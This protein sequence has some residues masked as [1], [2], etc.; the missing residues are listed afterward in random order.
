MIT[1]D[2][3]TAL[4]KIRPHTT[5]KQDHQRKPAQLLVALEST[6]RETSNPIKSS[7]QS[8]TAYFAA[9]IT[10]LEGCLS[11]G[12]TTLNE[13]DTLPAIL[14]LLALVFPF[15]PEP[16]LRSHMSK[17]FQIIPPLLPL[18]IPSHAPSLRSLITI[19]GTAIAAMDQG[20][21]LATVSSSVGSSSSAISV[22]IRQTFS[23]ILELVIDPRPKVRKRAGEVIKTV[24][25]NPPTPLFTHPWSSLVAE[26]SCGAVA[27][28]AEVGSS[29]K[30]GG[31]GEGLERLIHLFAFLRTVPSIFA[32]NSS[33]KGDNDSGD[34]NLEIITRYLLTMPKLSN[35]YLTQSSYQLL[36]ALLSSGM[37]EDDS[38][39]ESVFAQRR[40]VQV[41]SILRTLLSNV[42]SKID[43]QI[44]PYWLNVIS[45]AT[46]AS[47]ST[48]LWTNTTSSDVSEIW[49]TIWAFL[50]SSCSADTRGAAADA[51][52]RIITGRCIAIE[53][54]Q[55]VASQGSR[56]MSSAVDL[57]VK[58]IPQLVFSS[59]ITEILNVAATIAEASS[60]LHR[61]YNLE[62]GSTNNQVEQLVPISNPAKHH[63]M[64]KAN[65]PLL[66]LLEV[67]IKLRNSKGFEY[68]EDVDRFLSSMMR[69]VGVDGAFLRA[70]LGLLPSE[71]CV[72]QHILR[73]LCTDVLFIQNYV[74]EATQCLPSSPYS[75]S[76]S[77]S[78]FTFCGIFYPSIGSAL[79][80]C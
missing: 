37:D 55:G 64:T 46:I 1:D 43:H 38:Q 25:E 7:E 34:S 32:S 53:E 70:P 33:S 26:W 11:R 68:K 17:T 19:F 62:P 35:P 63:E 49:N 59:S 16:V 41:H 14:Y 79:G 73:F 27:Q 76:S 24:L 57:L 51:L 28:V 48:N 5:S 31:S 9:L 58:S 42:P 21:I 80:A 18:A 15:V 8:P 61:S 13:G 10:T 30:G 22:S 74:R 29:R 60:P 75:C 2:F 20:Q 56:F 52:E 45:Q 54:M 6:L 69:A 4:L 3:V 50:D 39:E 72:R 23:T 65:H 47:Y 12:D 40:R 77:Y 66:P 36:T 78:P 67:V 71:R 44:A